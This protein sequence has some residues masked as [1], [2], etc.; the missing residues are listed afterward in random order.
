MR[1]TSPGTDFQKRGAGWEDAAAGALREAEAR[2]R[3]AFDQAPI[4]MALV[5][6][7][8]PDRGRYL[9]VNSAHCELSGYP[10]PELLGTRP[11][12]HIHADDAA[13]DARAMDRLITGEITSY[14]REQ[15][16]LARLVPDETGQA[17][18][19]V[20]QAQ[21]IDQRK[22]FQSIVGIVRGL[23]KQTI[24]EF[25]GDAATLDVLHAEGVD[26]A[27]GHHVGSPRPIAE[28]LPVS[29]RRLG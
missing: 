24:A 15:R 4:G 5:G 11:R 26:Y 9:H 2:F 28:T 21:D 29:T 12:G 18:Y 14:E 1:A 25:V 19:C 7:A 22:R 20:R 6:L 13:D 8:G 16:W 17:L 27:Q 23:G 10:A 3:G